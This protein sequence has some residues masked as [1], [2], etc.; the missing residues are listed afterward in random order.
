VADPTQ[1]SF[2][3]EDGALAARPPH[4]SAPAPDTI[5]VENGALAARRPHSSAPPPHTW[6][7]RRVRARREKG[8]PRV[9]GRIKCTH[10]SDGWHFGTVVA[11]VAGGLWTVHFENND[12]HDLAATTLQEPVYE[13]GRAY[14]RTAGDAG[15][16]SS[17]E[18][19]KF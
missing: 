6:D 10:F 9:G 14:S 19:L 11:A 8:V 3:A 2:K 16:G 17:A 18:D 4:S 7:A 13:E 5:K 12:V 15:M 1:Q